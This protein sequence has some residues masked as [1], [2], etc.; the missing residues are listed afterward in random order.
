MTLKKISKRFCLAVKLQ[1]FK[2]LVAS[3]DFPGHP[4]DLPG[5][6]VQ[7]VGLVRR[8]QVDGGQEKMRQAPAPEA[9]DQL[10]QNPLL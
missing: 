4:P 5:A 1:V 7:A 6:N 10:Q 9:G 2:A 8:E 3:D